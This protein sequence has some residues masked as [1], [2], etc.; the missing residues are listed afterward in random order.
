MKVCEYNV[1]SVPNDTHLGGIMT[2]KAEELFLLDGISDEGKKRFFSDGRIY[3][4]SYKSGDVIYDTSDSPACL[5][6]ILSGAVKA[7]KRSDNKRVPMRTIQ[8]GEVFGAASLFGAGDGYVTVLTAKGATSVLFIPQ[9]CVRELVSKE[10]TAAVNYICFLSDKI[11]FL[12][13]RIDFYTALNA[14]EKLYEYLCKVMDDSGYASLTVNRAQLAKQ[15]DMGRASLY[16]AFDA[17]ISD[18]RI[19]PCEKGYKI[20]RGDKK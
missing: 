14:Q 5:G 20:L 2:V 10:S 16:R 3:S 9:E 8:A 12:N 13:S 17:L 6:L 4:R 1:N 7:E 11:R 19:C 18:G 15:L